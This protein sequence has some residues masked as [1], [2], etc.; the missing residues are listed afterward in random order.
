MFLSFSQACD[1]LQFVPIATVHTMMWVQIQGAQS[2]RHDRPM[3]A[4]HGQTSG[5]FK[6][7][8]RRFSAGTCSAA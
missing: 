5:R 6:V 4:E 1:T 2:R 3:C 8:R 7:W